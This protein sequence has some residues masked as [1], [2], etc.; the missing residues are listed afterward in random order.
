MATFVT[1]AST[2]D[3]SN[4]ALAETVASFTT[5]SLKQLSGRLIELQEGQHTLVTT[6]AA[7]SSELLG[8]SPE[9]AASRAILDKVP[10]YRAKAERLRTNMAAH[11]ARLEKLEKAAAGLRSKLEEKDRDRSSKKAADSTGYASV[12]AR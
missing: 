8:S 11:S 9:W 7:K 6:I 5:D 4:T 3:A 2:P 1:S 10:E 12:A